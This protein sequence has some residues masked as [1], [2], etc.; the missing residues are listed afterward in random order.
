MSQG[1]RVPGTAPVPAAAPYGYGSAGQN[2]VQV[3]AHVPARTR[4]M[5]RI[6]LF[7]GLLV[8]VAVGGPQGGSQLSMPSCRPA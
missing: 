4:C 2:G 3:H 8:F 6:A 7:T 1:A 5:S